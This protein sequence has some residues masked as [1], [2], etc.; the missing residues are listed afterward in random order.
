M[1]I[2]LIHYEAIRGSKIMF[3]ISMRLVKLPLALFYLNLSL[4]Q[5]LIFDTTAFK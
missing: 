1:K 2:T 4:L 3:N 5:P